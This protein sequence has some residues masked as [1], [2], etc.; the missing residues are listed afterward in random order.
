MSVFKIGG[1]DL[2][3]YTERGSYSVTLQPEGGG[4]DF[5]TA[6]GEVISGN[7]GDRVIISAELVSVPD[8]YARVISN[9]VSASEFGVT[10]S[11]PCTAAAKLHKTSYKAYAKKKAAEWDISLTITS[12]ALINRGGCL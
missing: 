7:V 12:A 1:I 10:Y 5:T 9:A 4:N 2:I 11:T 6:N 8:E 3:P